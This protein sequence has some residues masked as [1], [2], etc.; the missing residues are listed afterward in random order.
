MIHTL[1]QEV[2]SLNSEVTR[3]RLMVE[4]CVELQLESKAMAPPAAP[5]SSPTAAL[6]PRTP[7]ATDPLQI[8]PEIFSGMDGTARLFK[9]LMDAYPWLAPTVVS[10]A[11]EVPI[12]PI[13]QT[14]RDM[15]EPVAPSL[16]LV[17]PSPAPNVNC[18]TNDPT[19]DIAVKPA[20]SASSNKLEPPHIITSSAGVLM[21]PKKTKPQGGSKGPKMTGTLSRFLNAADSE[22]EE[23]AVDKLRP[24]TPVK[25]LED[26]LDF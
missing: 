19:T 20:V 17:D 6:L 22:E 9:L 12:V 23:A 10:S 11:K 2:C 13:A 5:S 7:L 1:E 14:N 26:E 8:L 4:R 18:A 24:P 15:A 3:L 16:T 21:L 25:Q